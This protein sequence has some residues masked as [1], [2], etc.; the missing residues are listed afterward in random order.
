MAHLSEQL[1]VE[2]Y[3]RQRFFTIHGARQGVGES[4]ILAIRH[5]SNGVEAHHVEVQTSFRPV[6]YL[7]NSNAKRRTDADVV[8]EMKTWLDKKYRSDAKRLLRQS[9]WPLVEWKFVFVHARLADPR[10]LNEMSSEGIVLTP[11][12]DVLK[13]IAKKTKK[14]AFTAHA[15]GDMSEIL[16]YYEEVD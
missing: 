16:R 3:N 7:S 2:F 12:R 15:G 1:V 5:T 10:E 9:V 13:A 6:G 8:S 4:D 11:F 14:G